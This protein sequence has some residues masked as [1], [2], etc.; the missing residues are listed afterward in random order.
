MTKAE[1]G[2][3]G[4]KATAKKYGNEHMAEIGKKG[5]EATWEK[6]TLQ[7]AGTSR[8]AMV[9]KETNQIVAYI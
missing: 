9:N 1:A 5:A 8:F 7:P 4:G 6:Y 3:L 2:R